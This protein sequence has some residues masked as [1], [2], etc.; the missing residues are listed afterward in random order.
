METSFNKFTW[1]PGNQKTLRSRE[2]SVKH[3]E[4]D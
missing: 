2:E 3:E 1:E 4:I